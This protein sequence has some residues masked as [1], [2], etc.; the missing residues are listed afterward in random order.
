MAVTYWRGRFVNFNSGGS[1]AVKLKEWDEVVSKWSPTGRIKQLERPC[2]S[3]G[4][5][6]RIYLRGV[7]WARRFRF[8]VKKGVEALG[9][10]VV[11]DDVGNVL[12]VKLPVSGYFK[13]A[14][15]EKEPVS[16]P[17]LGED[18]SRHGMDPCDEAILNRGG[19]LDLGTF[20]FEEWV[21]GN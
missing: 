5:V 7:L 18:I 10:T 8:I 9:V 15:K 16:V 4:W 20:S 6:G 17:G 13:D 19:G 3:N 11:C 2:H 1:F 14:L 21:S 12:E